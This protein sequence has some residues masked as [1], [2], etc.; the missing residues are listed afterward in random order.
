VRRALPWRQDDAHESPG[1]SMVPPRVG[2]SWWA[3]YFGALGGFIM[4]MAEYA[5]VHSRGDES[6]ILRF[7][8]GVRRP[9][10]AQ[11]RV[12]MAVVRGEPDLKNSALVVTY[13]C[14]ECGLLDR[15]HIE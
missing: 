10:C 13:R 3:I 11:C 1:P 15:A 5:P 12:P 6:N 7:R 4:S 14:S 9:L 8:R 2:G